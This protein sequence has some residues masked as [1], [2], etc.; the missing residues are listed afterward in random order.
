MTDLALIKWK[1]SESYTDHWL[2]VKSLRGESC[3][4]EY[5]VLAIPISKIDEI[6]D[7]LVRCI[8]EKICQF[9]GEEFCENDAYTNF[10]YFQLELYEV[11]EVVNITQLIGDVA[12]FDM[13]KTFNNY[14]NDDGEL[15]LSRITN[16]IKEGKVV[17]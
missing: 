10:G 13:V 11:D 12:V 17:P 5:P 1:E 4:E 6:N 9:D 7:S 14:I 2:K 16:D 15:M 8:G 3:S